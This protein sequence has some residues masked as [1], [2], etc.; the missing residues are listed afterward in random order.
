M[1]REKALARL[2]L[3][4]ALTVAAVTILAALPAHNPYDS[5]S[6]AQKKATKSQEEK[7]MP[8]AVYSASLIK[9]ALTA[10][11]SLR[12]AGGSAF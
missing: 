7:T 12:F 5:A 8:L 10:S 11:E 2:L 9:T 6:A 1:R 3:V 4:A